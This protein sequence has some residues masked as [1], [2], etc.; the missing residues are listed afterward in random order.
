MEQMQPQ[1][2]KCP[3][4]LCVMGPSDSGPDYCP[5]H[6]SPDLFEQAKK[7]VAKPEIRKMF[8]G[9]ARTWKDSMLSKNRI[10]EIMIY[11]RNMDFKR[12]GLAFC[13]GLAGE[14]EVVSALFEK[15]GFEVVSGC[16]MTGGFS[17]D[18]VGLSQED[19]IYAGG[20]QPQ[21]NPVGQAL[22][23]NKYR[24][25]LNVILGL[26]VGDDALF[27]KHSDAPIT[28]LAVK[29]RLNAHN[30]LAAI[31]QYRESLGL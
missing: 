3:P 1:C 30:P 4:K 28:V 29:D 18:D 13:I 22:L 21:C 24:T 23:M 9:V 20:R 10:E 31:P 12:L 27:I 15:E 17:S 7:I 6:V 25:D 14:A 16:C 11:A 26:C 2:A 5:M 8:R 19:K